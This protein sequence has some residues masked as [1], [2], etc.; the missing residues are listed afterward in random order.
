LSS[1]HEGKGSGSAT[2]SKARAL[3]GV[4]PV[5]PDAIEALRELSRGGVQFAIESVG[6]ERVLA[7]A[8]A[9]TR[10]GG[11]TVAV[12]LP[13]PDRM[14][15][16]PALKLVTEERT[17]KGSYMGSAVPSRDVPRFIA[18]YRAGY[19]PVDRMLTHRL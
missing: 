11:T 1:S 5:G 14:L 4:S 13:G 8:Y 3:C 12:G 7:Q 2:A 6:S 10:R 18:L 16:I 15:A 9:A 17:L 19:L